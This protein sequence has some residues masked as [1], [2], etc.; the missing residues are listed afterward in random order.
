MEILNQSI[1]NQD[2]EKTR[3]THWGSEMVTKNRSW[4][5]KIGLKQV[6]ANMRQS[7]SSHCFWAISHAIFRREWEWNTLHPD[8]ATLWARKQSTLDLQTS[9]EIYQSISK[10]N[11]QLFKKPCGKNKWHMR[12]ESARAKNYSF[13]IYLV[14]EA[15]SGFRKHLILILGYKRTLR[16]LKTGQGKWRVLWNENHNNQS[17]IHWSKW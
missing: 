9:A 13:E 15:E 14:H 5:I 11:K 10:T 2:L 16:L 6:S 1:K 7:W 3:N 12:K 4:K 17:K 8:C